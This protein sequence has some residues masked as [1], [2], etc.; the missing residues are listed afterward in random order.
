LP[1]G[2]QIIAAIDED[3]TAIAAA[4]MIAPSGAP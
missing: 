3:L 1:R 4:A 2:V